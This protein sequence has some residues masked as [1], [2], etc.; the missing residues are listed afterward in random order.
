MLALSS[1]MSLSYA[2][3]MS[4]ATNGA[5][6]NVMMKGSEIVLA[7]KELEGKIMAVVD[8][9]PGRTK[10]AAMCSQMAAAA[11]SRVRSEEEDGGCN[12]VGPPFTQ[13]TGLGWDVSTEPKNMADM[14]ALAI[15]QNPVVGFWDPL[16]IVNED[17][18]PE[19]IGW[20]RHAEI[21]HG[22]VAMAGFIGYCVHANNIYFPWN[23]QAKL[24]LGPGWFATKDLTDIS[25]GDIS[26]AGA[27][28]DMWD[29]LPTAAKV[30]I[31]C[32]IGFLEMHGENSLALEADGQ[33]HY[34]RGGKP[35]YYP[36]FKGRYP[37]PVP[38]DLWDPFGFTKNMSPERKEKA[39][40]AEVN[41]G[42]LAM[43]G[44]F[45]MI[46]AS[47]GLQVPGLDSV[48]IKPYAGEIMAPFTAA[49]ASLPFVADMLKN[50]GTYGY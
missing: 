22:R 8:A 18:A 50:V 12:A 15:K 38:L 47:K 20:F 24:D 17:T 2:P 1:Q 13:A 41:N 26:A 46:S 35:G 25:F 7:D 27:P 5:R 3:A 42:R 43:I 44:I 37:H 33:K 10:S 32:V 14:Q 9:E 6:A 49:D 48:G 30:Q 40:L 11:L 45:G 31:G 36:S 23:I 19:T 39:L 28:G 4:F 34:V 21:K 29:A 16:N